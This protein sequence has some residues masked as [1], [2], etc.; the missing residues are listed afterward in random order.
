MDEHS[1]D[2]ENAERSRDNDENIRST[3]LPNGPP[4]E[5]SDKKSL[6]KT[7]PVAL[8]LLMT[9]TTRTTV[10]PTAE[11]SVIVDRRN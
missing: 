4:A 6:E 11:N 9:L 2:T 10:A 1:G 7:L 5:P 8:R 3:R